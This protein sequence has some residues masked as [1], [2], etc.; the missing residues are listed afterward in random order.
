MALLSC[1]D[2]LNSKQCGTIYMYKQSQNRRS[3]HFHHRLCF[4][5]VT[6]NKSHD[7]NLLSMLNMNVYLYKQS[8]TRT[9]GVISCMNDLEQERLVSSRV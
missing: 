5:V 8:R 2:K 9:P 3:Y 1:L 4:L 7:I 6:R